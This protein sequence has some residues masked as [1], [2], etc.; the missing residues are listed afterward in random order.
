MEIR[1]LVYFKELAEE[2][3]LP[4]AAANLF[5]TPQ[6]LSKSIHKLSEE[7]GKELF[8]R[9][10]G[11]L[12]LTNFGQTFYQETIKILN[13]IQ[14]MEERLKNIAQ[15]ENDIIH[16]ACSHGLIH[17]NLEEFIHYFEQQYPNVTL[18]ITELPDVIAEAYLEQEEFDLAFTVGIPDNP[19]EFNCTL[20]EKHQVAAVIH[21]Q[22]PLAEKKTTSLKECSAYPIYTKN[23][24]FKIYSIVENAAKAQNI[25]LNYQLQ[26]PNEV[27]W[28][29]KVND[30][31]GI[32]IGTTFY[33]NPKI[34]TP[35]LALPFEEEELAWNIY[36]TYKKNHYLSEHTHIFMQEI[37]R[38][39]NKLQKKPR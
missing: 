8:H 13:E 5:I 15:Q 2:L 31:E 33:S 32:G 37:K 24:F 26:S 17:G 19:E 3:N 7:F 36:L 30:Q 16:I 29:Q 25:K 38:Y 14:P 4:S 34:L 1:Q 22:H 21:P 12:E 39:F 20:L 11:K 9:E 6:A 35:F 10:K 23:R 18:D 27:I 28:R